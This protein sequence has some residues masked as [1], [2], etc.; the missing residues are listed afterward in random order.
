MSHVSSIISFI[1]DLPYFILDGDTYHVKVQVTDSSTLYIGWEW[2]A[3]IIENFCQFEVNG[4][5]GWGCAEFCYRHLQGRP[6]SYAQHDPSWAAE[7][8]KG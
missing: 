5:K 6:K 7:I 1:L 4:V 3:R 2:E 8:F